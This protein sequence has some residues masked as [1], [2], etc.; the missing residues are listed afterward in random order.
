M[1]GLHDARRLPQIPTS[2]VWLSAFGMFVLRLRS[3]NALEQELRIGGR[4]ETWVGQRKPSADTLGRVFSKMSPEELRQILQSIHR[5]AWRRKAIH[6]RQGDSYRVLAVDGY[7]IGASRARCCPECLVREKKVG[8][9]ESSEYYHRFVVAQWVGV[10]P[11]P[12]ADLE[13]I[14]PGE[15][16]VVA[17]RRLLMRVL[18]D[19]SRLVDVITVDALY[20]EAPFLKMVLDAGK[21]VVVVMKQERRDL[22]Q[23]AERLRG[24]TE[25]RV[26]IEGPRTTR[27][28]DMS[29]MTS[30]QTLER[31]V[32]VVWAE[33]ETRSRKIVGGKATDLL[34]EK[35]W[36]WVTDLP[37]ATV[38]PGKIQRWGHDR[39]DLE[40]RGL[41]ELVNLWHMGHYFIHDPIAIEALLL[42][43]AIAFVTS[44]LFYERNLK[45][46][47]RL[48]LT[49]LALAA[50]L[51]E[52]LVLLAG[53]TI[54]SG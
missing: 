30:F 23:D 3:F 19:Y 9:I 11:P 21:H 41:N 48:H 15:G 31:P 34:E 33:E 12:I 38:P 17:A 14:R 42:T 25:P 16:E 36:I 40:N 32:R 2:S 43:L 54:W 10:T 35:T 37:A 47:A 26:V 28:W 22:Y 18:R 44:Y 53:A 49:R 52:D 51:G 13:R 45:S 20:L 27:F 1:A 29:D 4:W 5:M 8:E 50:R 7:E 24:L 46:Q 39:W 6:P